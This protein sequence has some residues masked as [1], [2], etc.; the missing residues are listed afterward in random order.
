[1][2]SDS[3]TGAGSGDDAQHICDR[4]E[5]Q[6]SDISMGF[7]GADGAYDSA[8]SSGNEIDRNDDSLCVVGG[9]AIAKA[10]P[11]DAVQRGEYGIVQDIDAGSSSV[12][13][14]FAKSCVWVDA[15]QAI[16]ESV[17]GS[18]DQTSPNLGP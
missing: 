11:T 2:S 6:D 16:P 9:L 3:A 1:M 12:L 17:F 14:R 18:M 8:A 13:K 4:S 15:A 10:T 7:A 5:S